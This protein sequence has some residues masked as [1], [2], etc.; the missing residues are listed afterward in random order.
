V[1]SLNSFS[2]GSSGG[3]FALVEKMLKDMVADVQ[4]GE[5]GKF[6]RRR[7]LA[8]QMLLIR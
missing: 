4:L 2:I 5:N 8:F 3:P 7:L 6:G 1:E